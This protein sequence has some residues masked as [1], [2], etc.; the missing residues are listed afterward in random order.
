MQVEK[1]NYSQNF[2]NKL[3]QKVFNGDLKDGTK[4]FVRLTFNNN[5]SK[6]I[7]AVETYFFKNDE[8]IG[9]KGFGRPEGVRLT[10]L[11][12]WLTNLQKNAK[13]G[14]DFIRKYTLATR[15]N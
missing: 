7:N 8:L 9:G 15:R 14:V 13:N 1:I 3:V 2:G 6:Q 10:E 4:T 11:A 12:A 5:N